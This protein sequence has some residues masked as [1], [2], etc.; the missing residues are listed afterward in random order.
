MPS[1]GVVMIVRDEARTLGRCLQSVRGW[2]DE[3][4]V[5]DTGSTDSTVEIAKAFGATVHTDEWHN[6]FAEARNQALER[7]TSDWRLVL[8]AD[9]W[10]DPLFNASDLRSFLEGPAQ[11]GLICVRSAFQLNKRTEQ[12]DTW[13]PR[14]LPSGI[15]YEGRI[16]EQPVHSLAQKRLGMLVH[17]D[18]YTPER[19]E[20]KRARNFDLL[21]RDLVENPDSAYLHFQ[22]GVQ[23]DA[24]HAWNLAAGAYEAAIARGA[25]SHP[26]A[27]SL[28][29]R[30]LH[31]LARCGRF[32]TAA[33]VIEDALKL[34]PDSTDVLFAVGNIYLDLAM[35][36]PVRA[37]SLWLPKAESAWL[38]CLEIGERGSEEKDGHVIGRGSFLAA[39]NLFILYQGLGHKAE[40]EKF[41]KLAQRS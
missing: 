37:L 29:V 8:D 31:A 22:L 21:T 32:E 27:H 6:H 16:H 41:S 14:L 7:S 1:I 4:V 20:I 26:F 12:S 10:V 35:A 17:H 30:R 9:E 5:S 34:W 40:A 28:T 18:G 19:L 11:V 23:H 33:V 25:M 39:H 36:E 24:D 15:R 3:I 13:L 38:R 2:V